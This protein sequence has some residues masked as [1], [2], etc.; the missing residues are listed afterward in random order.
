MKRLGRLTLLVIFFVPFQVVA[1]NPNQGG[2]APPPPTLKRRISNPLIRVKTLGNLPGV[3][4]ELVSLQAA[5][6]LVKEREERKKGLHRRSSSL[7][8]LGSSDNNGE[9]KT[10]E[11]D[12]PAVEEKS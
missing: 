4:D 11:D 1:M 5:V 9:E 7:L 2:D 3:D 8:S 12:V 6:A 10:N